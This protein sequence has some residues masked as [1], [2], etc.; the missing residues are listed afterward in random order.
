MVELKDIVHICVPTGQNTE[1]LVLLIDM[2][3]VPL[4]C[5]ERLKRPSRAE[6]NFN[7]FSKDPE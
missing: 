6:F 2:I 3:E 5:I 7:E 4:N 1:G